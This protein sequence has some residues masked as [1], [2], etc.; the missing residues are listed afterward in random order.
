M[1]KIRYILEIDNQDG[2]DF[3]SLMRI[4]ERDEGLFGEIYSGNGHWEPYNGVF[5]YFQDPGLADYIDEER[6]FAIMKII[7]NQ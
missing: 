4:V 1:E 5:S 7:D 3:Y 6:A 2:E